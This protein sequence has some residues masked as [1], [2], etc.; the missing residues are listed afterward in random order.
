MEAARMLPHQY[1]VACQPIEDTLSEGR[2]YDLVVLTEILE[3]VEDPVAILRMARQCAKSVVAS[4]PLIPY[5]GRL[6]DNPE[7]LWQFDAPGYDEML[8]E[9]GWTPITFVPVTLTPVQFVYDFQIWG[10]Q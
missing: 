2:V 10:A 4:S 6:D 3:H 7:H 1:S 8:K 5:N 9:A